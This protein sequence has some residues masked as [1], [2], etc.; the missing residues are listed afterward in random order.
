MNTISFL[1]EDVLAE[2]TLFR[3]EPKCFNSNKELF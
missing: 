1:T 2:D 3:Y